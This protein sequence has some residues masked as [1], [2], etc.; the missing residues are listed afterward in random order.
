[1]KSPIRRLAEKVGAAKERHIERHRPTGFDFALADRIDL[2]N[3]E[4]WDQ[5]VDGSSLFLSRP[6]LQMLENHAPTNVEPRYALISRNNTPV[7]A[8]VA[9]SVEVQGA[10]LVQEGANSQGLAKKEQ[11]RSKIR[12]ALMATARKAGRRIEERVLVC[13][14]L[15]SWGRHGVAFAA[16]TEPETLWPAIAE[17]LYRIRRSDKLLGD[18]SIVLLKDFTEQDKPG[19][20]ALRRFSYRPAE[21]DPDMVL[22]LNPKWR[23]L[24]D[25]L[26]SLDSKYRNSF[27]QVFRKLGEKD[28]QLEEVQDL[29]P[30]APRLHE[31]YCSVQSNAAVRP[32]TVPSSFLPAL[33]QLTSPNFRCTLARRGNEVLGFVTTL[34]DGATAI[35]YHIGFDRDEAQTGTPLYL[36]LLQSTV[37]H[38]IELRCQ[39][40]SLGR[41]ALEPKARLGAQPVPLHF[42]AR[43]KNPAVNLLL[44]RLLGH[45]PHDEAPE[46]NPFKK[47]EA[48]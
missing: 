32:V 42:W 8:V 24:D 10:K 29:H 33:A 17:A 27:K 45:I 6:F 39:S 2:L 36:G 37:R 7:A 14:N 16:D 34:K 15:L 48:Q 18:A 38:A 21:T 22:E 40:L 5:A 4:A 44:R 1:M 28:I 9:Q 26:G 20:N 23:Q 13:G 19:I 25:Y 35:G 30:L 11:E 31:L 41:T 43:H 46:R 12:S 3:P 47:S